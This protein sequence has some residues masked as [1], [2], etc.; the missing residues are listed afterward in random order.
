MRRLGLALSKGRRAWL[1][2]ALAAAILALPALAEA[3]ARDRLESA[4]HAR[5]GPNARVDLDL[6]GLHLRELAIEAKGLRAELDEL[7]VRPTLD[8]I[9]VELEAIH[10]SRAERPSEA[11]TPTSASA[12]E[13][14]PEPRL[15]ALMPWVERL[16]GVPVRVELRG[17]ISVPARGVALHAAEAWSRLDAEGHIRGKLTARIHREGEQS[18]RLEMSL[19][20]DLPRDRLTLEGAYL[21]AT[22]GRVDGRVELAGDEFAARVA[23]HEGQLSL[24][25][26]GVFEREQAGARFEAS[27]WPMASAR[28]LQRFA[29]AWLPEH[30]RAAEALDWQG[31]TLDGGIDLERSPTGLRAHLDDLSLHG[32][33][34]DN[35][36]LSPRPV[37]FARL[38]LDGDL[39]V[40]RGDE[41]PTFE[42]ALTL[43]HGTARAVAA[44]HWSGERV[45]LDLEIAAMPCQGLLDSAPRGLL[46]ALEGMR[47][48]GMVEGHLGL[49]FDWAKVR[50]WAR[51]SEAGEMLD[52]PGQLD[53]AF[54]VV[55]QC[56]VTRE[57]PGIDVAALEGA[58]RHRFEGEQ[59]LHRRVLADGAP[60]FAAIGSVPRLARAF[61]ILEDARFWRH[62][63]FD[64]EH[65]ERALWHDLGV[66]RFARGA[67]TITQQTARNLW[68]GVDRSVGRKLQE[69][70][71]AARLERSLDKHRILEIY[72]NIIELGPGVYGIEPAAQFYFGRSARELNTMEALHLA[73][74]APA[75]A[76]YPARFVSGELDPEWR[77]HLEEQVR[78]LRIHGWLT[79]EQA[80]AAK[81]EPVRLLDR[82]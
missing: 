11:A 54:P 30:A 7:R 32:L 16:H 66:G 67:S 45:D 42:G 18:E 78:R 31:A 50:D 52:S 3:D 37:E 64:L 26:H 56:R 21:T 82:R 70:F 75:P 72:M 9:L 79:R 17:P 47:V 81:D 36:R 68:L 44:G 55:D 65:I 49:H 51:R 28:I 43:A 8:G 20:V 53:F 39:R 80:R 4:V 13:D 27:A 5:V 24:R 34:V 10:I 60:E 57:A 19:D 22:L 62:E 40:S 58:Y 61:S 6:Q 29:R 69:A 46:P 15:S 33:R 35:A 38:S 77:A 59:R 73:S 2:G 48:A 23:H 76:T 63:G 41:A 25:G 74:L 12:S 14:A 71:L 1:G